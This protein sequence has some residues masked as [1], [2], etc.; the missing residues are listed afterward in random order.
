MPVSVRCRRSVAR[1]IAAG[2]RLNLAF[3]QQGYAGIQLTIQLWQVIQYI[4]ADLQR[5][6]IH[7]TVRGVH[8]QWH[9]GAHAQGVAI[10]RQA[11]LGGTF[12]QA[13]EQHGALRGGKV[14]KRL[15][16]MDTQQHFGRRSQV[17]REVKRANALQVAPTRRKAGVEL[18]A[19]SV[20]VLSVCGRTAC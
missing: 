5:A 4:Q 2:G 18:V 12:A 9:N 19:D 14:G 17:D 1:V 13:V 15:R 7:A 10:H 8:R 11:C 20:E 6:D 3:D 16:F